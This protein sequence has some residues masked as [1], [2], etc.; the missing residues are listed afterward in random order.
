M[1]ERGDSERHVDS[2]FAQ[3]NE[4]TL[5]AWVRT[6]LGCLGLGPALERGMFE[7]LLR[8]PATAPWARSVGLGLMALGCVGSVLGA[9]RHHRVHCALLAGAPLPV[10]AGPVVGFVFA[11]AVL[12]TALTVVAASR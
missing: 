5:L 9:Y 7:G 4:R 12:G 3:A 6:L 10:G 1:N 11:V 8:D 2:R